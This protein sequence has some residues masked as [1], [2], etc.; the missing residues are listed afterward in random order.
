MAD[1][2]LASL[3]FMLQRITAMESKIHEMPKMPKIPEEM[4]KLIHPNKSLLNMVW[5]GP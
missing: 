5:S 2:L 3:S 1:K 4:K